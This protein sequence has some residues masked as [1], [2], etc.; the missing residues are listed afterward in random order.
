[1]SIA[2]EPPRS[3]QRQREIS[4]FRNGYGELFNDEVVS[5]SGSPGRYLRWQWA[6]AGVLAIPVKDDQ[7][8]LVPA[9]R[10]PAGAVFLEFPRGAAN[11]GESAEAAAVR[12]LAEE[13]GLVGGG[14]R[15]LGTVYPETGLIE[16]YCNVVCVD[17]GGA[18]DRPSA[19]E[20][21]ESVG[22]PRWFGD[23]ALRKAIT[24]G[25]IRCGVTLA[26]LTLLWAAMDRP[27]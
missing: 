4:V 19:P 10:Y 14:S 7:I 23:G 21:M 12:E 11:E 13:T 22:T 24:E 18:A 1:M 26:A 5:P 16:S 3:I 15:I 20:V 25:Q 6:F 8:A 2:D 9:Y 27:S 17:V